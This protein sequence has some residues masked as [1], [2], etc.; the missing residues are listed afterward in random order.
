MALLLGIIALGATLRLSFLDHPPIWG[1]EAATFGRSSGTF[2]E[3]MARLQTA[4]FAPMHYELLWWIGQ[5]ALLTPFMLRLV[6]AITGTLMIPAMYWLAW[7]FLGRRAALLA[8]LLTATNAFLLNYSR[9]AKMYSPFWF[10]AV[11]H[12]A[13]LLWWLR[14]RDPLSWLAWLAAGTA[15]VGF[16]ALGWIVVFVELLIVLTAPRGNWIS[17]LLLLVPL[18]LIAAID[19]C[20]TLGMAILAVLIAGNVL[21]GWYKQAAIALVTVAALRWLWLLGSWLMRRR[22]AFEA[23]RNMRDVPEAATEFAPTERA[24]LRVRIVPLL[25][26]FRWPPIALF[27]LGILI[28]LAG[29]VGYYCDFNRY[30]SKID[31]HGWHG[32]GIDWVEP[33]NAGRDG[34]SLVAFTASAFVDSW[35]WP[36]AVDIERIGVRNLRLLTAGTLAIAAVL[37]LGALP[38]PWRRGICPAAHIGFTHALLWTLIWLTLPA[39]GFYLVSMRDAVGPEAWLKMAHD[40]FADPIHLGIAIVFLLGWFF[41]VGHNWKTRVLRSLGA[42]LTVALVLA[43]MQGLYLVYPMLDALLSSK[44]D[45]WQQHGSVWMPRYVAVILP[46]ALIVMTALLFNLPSKPLRWTCI[47]LVIAVNLSIHACRVFAG[48]EQP[49]GLMAADIL[50]SQASDRGDQS[51]RVYFDPSIPT[52]GAEPG[53]TS[54]YSSSIKYYITILSPRP[55]SGPVNEV[56]ADQM[57][58]SIRPHRF[59][60]MSFT[61]FLATDVLHLP[62]LKRFVVWRRLEPG[63]IDMTDEVLQLLSGRWRCVAEE[64]FAVRDHWRWKDNCTLQRRTYVRVEPPPQEA[65]AINAR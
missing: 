4:G 48:N 57:H 64:R 39:F 41:V 22:R 59:I 1:D 25:G 58:P 45:S 15:M 11:V 19:W 36:R 43:A 49:S 23:A 62:K 47:A 46:A 13:A 3:L 2:G 32:T 55:T 14:A 42:I 20:M 37:A 63:Q 26:R 10:F 33:Y 50:S 44:S 30:L 24:L 21:E 52:W 8:A 27:L 9:D 17:F 34:L 54:L 56:L 51:L 38:H 61:T 65:D 53:S 16:D 7:H 29:P 12:V 28:M 6:P 60:P 31:S 35:E 40:F 5:H 18:L